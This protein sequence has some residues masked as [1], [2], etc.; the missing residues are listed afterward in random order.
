MGGSQDWQGWAILRAY[1][2]LIFLQGSFFE[3]T[4]FLTNN[5]ERSGTHGFDVEVSNGM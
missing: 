5:W 3:N 4:Q 1:I 2:G